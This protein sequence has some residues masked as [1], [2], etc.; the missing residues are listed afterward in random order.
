M[1][2]FTLASLLGLVLATVRYS[3]T[4]TSDTVTEPIAPPVQTGKP[5]SIMDYLPA[6]SSF[7]NPLF[8]SAPAPSSIMPDVR[9]IK[10][11]LSLSTK[12]VPLASDAKVDTQAKVPKVKAGV[13]GEASTS[14]AVALRNTEAGL[15]AFVQGSTWPLNRKVAKKPKPSDTPIT[16]NETYG[17]MIIS[18]IKA[19]WAKTRTL[20][21]YSHAEVIHYIRDQILATIQLEIQQA[22]I[23]A[24]YVIQLSKNVT[25][26]ASQHLQRGNKHAIDMYEHLMAYTTSINVTAT[27]ETATNHAKS[28]MEAV[29]S[30]AIMTSQKGKEAIQQ[31][32]A[33]L[34]Y[35]VAEAKRMR[36]ETG[37]TKEKIEPV[38]IRS[39][40]D[41]IK[42]HR[43]RLRWGVPDQGKRQIPTQPLLARETSMSLKQKLM[44]ALHNVSPRFLLLLNDM[45]NEIGRYATGGLI[46]VRVYIPNSKLCVLSDNHTEA[47]GYVVDIVKY[48]F[49]YLSTYHLFF[50]VG[51]P[52]RVGKPK[53]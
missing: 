37:E 27:T 25:Q 16:S 33:G 3:T 24:R 20:S 46:Y 4:P 17:Q 28:G 52:C 51:Q 45:F 32:R 14:Y 13:T 2:I 31:A 8:D 48:S 7:S 1:S 40:K 5:F 35:L 11:A 22:L 21:S 42:S 9:L 47:G 50:F 30:K 19:A 15:M 26:S 43:G 18:D 38:R 41:K 23:L 6:S 12:A 44:Q 34:D 29:T 53:Q 39:F 10:N 36:G 49:I